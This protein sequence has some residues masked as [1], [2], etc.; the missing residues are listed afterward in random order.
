VDAAGSVYLTGVAGVGYPYTVTVPV[1]PL[2]IAIEK[3]ETPSPPFLTKLDPLGQNV[4]YSVP[5]G[6]AGVTVDANGSAYVGGILGS[7]TIHEADISA[8]LPALA[9]LPAGCFTPESTVGE[10]AYAAQV[11]PS[12]NVTGAQFIGGSTLLVNG[13]ALAGNS[14]WLAGATQKAD[15]PFSPGP[16]FSGNVQVAA[17]AGAYLGAVNFSATAPVAGTPQIGCVVDSGELEPTGPV[18]PNQLITIL[19]NGLG[20]ATGLA[21]TNYTTTSLDGVSVTFGGMAATLLYVSANQ[22]NVAVP[23]LPN[24]APTVMTVTVNGVPSAQLEFPV[25]AANPTMF[26]VP[27]GFQSNFGG[28][29][30][31]ALNADGTLN[32]ATNPAKP[33]SVIQVFVDGL[34]LNPQSPGVP[35]ALREEGSWW[36]DTRRRIRSCWMCRSRCRCQRRTSLVRE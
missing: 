33:G 9:N 4:L 1:A 6:G 27:G 30:V 34:S 18:A 13:V 28:F 29:D 16:M 2:S 22:I 12:E 20:P 14:L 35:P 10:Q 24:G 36:R 21:A 25:A 3:L 17:P 26:A 7:F 23:I 15:F 32:S 19:G 8:T 11:D 5:V 31:V